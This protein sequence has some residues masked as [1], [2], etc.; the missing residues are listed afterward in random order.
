M[1]T[2]P[3]FESDFDC[4]TDSRKQGKQTNNRKKCLLLK[5]WPRPTMP[6]PPTIKNSW[7]AAEASTEQRPSKGKNKQPT[8]TLR[9]K[10]FP[11]SSPAKMRENQPNSKFKLSGFSEPSFSPSIVFLP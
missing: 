1:G 5:K 8:P 7:E 6:A 4:L 2:H 11:R 9:R 3:I 10:P